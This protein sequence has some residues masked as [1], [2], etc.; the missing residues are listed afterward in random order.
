MVGCTRSAALISRGGSIDWLCWPRFDSESI[1]GRILDAEKGGFFA[2]RPAMPFDARRRYLDG[3]NVIETTF[4]TESG[5]ARLLDLMPVMTEEEKKKR[6][7][8]F[9]QLLRRVEVVAGELP[10]EVIYAP[11]PDYGRVTPKLIMRRDSVY[12]AW[13][14]RVLRCA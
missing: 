9:R 5:V 4:S 6:L 14:A 2:I 12:C 11:R 7:S 1:F 8:P 13:G 10:I 3:T